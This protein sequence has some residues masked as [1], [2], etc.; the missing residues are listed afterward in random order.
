MLRAG[1]SMEHIA[2][3]LGVSR[4]T[5]RN[6]L[7]EEMLRL[8]VEVQELQEH[9]QSLSIARTEHLLS[10]VMPLI[11]RLSS[12]GEETEID[13]IPVRAIN[14]TIRSALSIIKL[15]KELVGLDRDRKEAKAP[16]QHNT[17]VVSS[18][19]YQFALESMRTDLMVG[20]DW[21]NGAE[22]YEIAGAPDDDRIAKLEEV[23][24]KL[25]VEEDAEDD[26]SGSAD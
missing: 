22:E 3:E 14:E 7:Q 23:V 2:S 5:V 25:P 21:N 18:E 24:S 4:E 1:Y 12:A 13:N 10:K 6:Y 20:F 17:L 9:F 15:Q 11:D 19:L 26:G 16:V 8:T